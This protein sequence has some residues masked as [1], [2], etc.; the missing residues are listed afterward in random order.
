MLLR[1]LNLETVFVLVYLLQIIVVKQWVRSRVM[2]LT[3]PSTTFQLPY[4]VA[5]SFIGGVKTMIS[6][7]RCLQGPPRYTVTE[8][9]LTVALNT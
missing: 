5:I 6:V 3:P 7:E 2:C 1:L 4:I 9:L 8:M